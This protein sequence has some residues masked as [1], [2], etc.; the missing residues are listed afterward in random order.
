MQAIQYELDHLRCINQGRPIE[1]RAIC[2]PASTELFVD[3]IS[4]PDIYIWDAWAY[5]RP[6]GVI[7]LFTLAQPRASF[8]PG[9]LDLQTQRDILPHHWRRFDSMDDGHSWSDQGPVFAPKT[10]AKDESDARSIWTGSVARV[11]DHVVAA[12]TG[13]AQRGE[14]FPYLQSLSLA[15][16]DTSSGKFLAI[17]NTPLLCPARDYILIKSHGY[18]LGPQ[19]LLGHKSGEP[20][21]CGLAWRD[22]ALF[23]DLSGR[24][25]L[26][27]AAKACINDSP[28]PAIGHG[29]VN[30][31]KGA[32]R[33][34]ITLLPPISLSDADQLTQAEVPQVIYDKQRKK[35]FMMI[36]T[37]NK[38]FAHQTDAD[39][40][41]FV[42]LYT[43]EELGH[44]LVLDRILLE[45]RDKRYP[46]AIIQHQDGEL[47]F[48]AP[49]NRAN[50][51]EKIH[52]MPHLSRL[53]LDSNT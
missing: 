10:A 48:M 29:I 47:S 32:L 8:G 17:T 9:L 4:H 2:P 52:T 20:G 36:S 21:P 45:P 1:D 19:H 23:V 28:V 12:Y 25:H 53:Q 41:L 24:I 27:W 40:E 44:C 35:Y 15:V 30:I 7:S 5:T 3:G 6:N 33:P 18:H 39:G 11:G 37:T 22:P 38:R 42:K 14:E 50:S 26:F 34:T 46:G 51:P 16:E 13:I 43:C 49:F 31:I